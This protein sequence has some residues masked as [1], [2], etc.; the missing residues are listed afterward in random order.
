MQKDKDR[1]SA[2]P[3][4]TW[5]DLLEE[6]ED[7][8]T[9]G[10]AEESPAQPQ[11]PAAADETL[12]ATA[13]V[14]LPP[15][16]EALLAEKERLEDELK[17][18][19][20]LGEP[21]PEDERLKRMYPVKVHTKESRIEE[22]RLRKHDEHQRMLKQRALEAKLARAREQQRQAEREAERRRKAI[23]KAQAAIRAQQRQAEREAD[24][25]RNAIEKALVQARWANDRQKALIRRAQERRRDALWQE[26]CLSNQRERAIRLAR[27][28]KEQ[29]QDDLQKEQVQQA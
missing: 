12:Q 13:K 24:R 29:Q 27:E 17:R 7:G 14:K 16:V 5:Q 9:L 6:S 25:Q 18:L 20:G 23:E 2:N 4:L 19:A 21:R 11:A 26:Q 8:A 22:R 10:T 15:D 1:L 3:S 28:R